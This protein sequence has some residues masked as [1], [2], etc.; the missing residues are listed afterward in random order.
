MRRHPIRTAL[1]D[2]SLMVRIDDAVAG[3]RYKGATQDC[4]DCDLYPVFRKRKQSSFAHVPRTGGAAAHRRG[5]SASHREACASWH[6]FFERLLSECGACR[7]NGLEE[8]NH[9]CPAVSITGNPVQLGPPMFGEIVWVCD[10]CMKVH[11]WDLLADGA[12]RVLRERQLPGSLI[13]PDITVLDKDDRPLAL[14]EFQGSHLS[15]Q[16]KCVA[17]CRQI[18]LFVVDVERVPEVFQMGLQNPRR[19]MFR[20]LTDASGHPYTKQHAWADQ[21]SYRFAE[22]VGKE[23]NVSSEFA[24]VPDSHGNLAD[25]HF[26]AAGRS[27]ALPSPSLGPYLVATWSNLKCDS[28]RRWLEFSNA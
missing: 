27:T 13:R 28:Q 1:D 2:N 12:A 16:V 10:E 22:G 25:V 11:M 5:Q 6:R 8:D 7:L 20:V 21:V 18:P 19:G 15:R 14:I 3:N 23:G 17:K 4:Q 24:P 9:V 26:H